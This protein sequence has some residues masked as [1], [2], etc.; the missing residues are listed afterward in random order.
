MLFGY[1]LA[2]TASWIH[3]LLPQSKLLIANPVTTA[4]AT[5]LVFCDCAVFAAVVIVLA[6][7]VIRMAGG[8]ERLVLGKWPGNVGAD[9]IAV[10]ALTAWIAAMVTRVI[11][12]TTVAE[13]SRRPAPGRMTH[14]ALFG[15]G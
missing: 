15:C 4:A 13:V 6:L 11:A 2:A 14:V 3:M 8:T 7:E 9:C 12:L 10:A 5:V 1:H